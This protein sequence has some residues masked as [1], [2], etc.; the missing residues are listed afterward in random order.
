MDN[1]DRKDNKK[2]FNIGRFMIVLI[3]AL[4][5]TYFGSTFLKSCIKMLKMQKLQL[6]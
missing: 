4:I 1:N 5:L 3:V 6:L 2:G